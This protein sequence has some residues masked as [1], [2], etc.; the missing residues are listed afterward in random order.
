MTER[1]LVHRLNDPE[2]LRRIALAYARKADAARMTAERYATTVRD[3][4]S[5]A[6]ADLKIAPVHAPKKDTRSRGEEVAVAVLSD[7]QLAKRTATYSSRICEQ[8]IE[9]F[10]DKV[11]RLTEIQR[12]DHP[13]K[14]LRVWCLGDLV[15]G[16]LIFPGQAHLIDA[17]LY[18]QT[19][20]DGPRIL[21]N[22]I[23]RM[24]AAFDLV[25]VTVVPGNHGRL[26]GRQSKDYH[27]DSNADRMLAGVAQ[28]ILRD[29][30]RVTWTIA[31]GLLEG[32]WYA[33][34]N[35]GG[36]KTLLFH[37]DQIQGGLTT[38]NHVKKLVLGW[39]AGAID[40]GFD[41]AFLGH[42][43]VVKKFTFNEVT[44]R[45]SGS[46]ESD[47]AYAVRALGSRSNPSQHLQ[48]VSPGRFVTAEYTVWL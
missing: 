29:E 26:G 10:A 30:P 9:R 36:F 7:W 40:G 22:F 2:A 43:H 21:V 8:R 35:I 33:I 45:V 27:P 15:E 11:V 17:S 3:A 14:T 32:G 41:E 25:H 31:G 1:S 20:V 18:S 34:D 37:G 13:V 12:S 44:V 46:P 16:E 47:N 39:K 24:L 48:F 23:R 28:Q 5:V 38:E 6:L 42:Y 4:V 19:I